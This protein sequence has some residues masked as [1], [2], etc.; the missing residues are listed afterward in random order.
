MT[1]AQIDQLLVLDAQPGP[2][3]PLSAADADV[4]VE[5]ALLGAGFGPAG[6]PGP[7]GGGAGAAG[8]GIGGFKIVAATLGIAVVIVV[9]A[10]LVGRRSTHE[11]AALPPD[12]AP[13]AA[14]GS[15]SAI[16]PA[17]A[18]AP[19]PEPTT[20]EPTAPE[21]TAPEPPPAPAPHKPADKKATEKAINDLLGEANA[22]RAA[23]AWRESDALYARVVKR[24]PGT[25]GAQTALVA[26]GS[27]HL[28]H[29]GDPR[30]AADRF[31]RALA[32]A[33]DA[34]MAEEA[35]WGLAEAARARGDATAEAKAL[36]D[37]L[38]HHPES[39]LAPKARARRQELK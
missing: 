14:L 17:T 13:D 27:L 24:A 22:K 3:L 37:F 34:A 5:A 23:H 18:T 11:V 15:G 32:I 7:S 2:A 12:A 4:L 38:A 31:K 33:P 9:I 21:P 39:P 20:P 25:L 28:E 30:G 1:E 16:G 19:I 29:L 6:G 8:R 36:D 35:R 10:I 26:S